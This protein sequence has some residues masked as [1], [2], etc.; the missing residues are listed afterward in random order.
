MKNMKTILGFLLVLILMATIAVAESGEKY[1][2]DGEKTVIVDMDDFCLYL[3]GDYTANDNC[4]GISGNF[5]FNLNCVIENKSDKVF[6]SV[7]YDGVI[8]GWS[9]GSVFG[10]NGASNIQ[11]G[12]KTKSSI[13]FT[14]DDTEIVSFEELESMSL[15]FYVKDEA[16]TDM[17]KAETGMIHFHADAQVVE[18]AAPEVISVEADQTVSTSTQVVNETVIIYGDYETL[19]VG[20]KG[21][22]VKQLQRTLIEKGFLSGGA[23]GIY[24]KGT[25]GGVSK[26]QESIGAEATGTAD[27]ETQKQLFGGLDVLAALKEETWFFN[28]GDDTILNVMSFTDSTATITQFVYDGNGRHE[29]GKNEYPYV[30]GNENI[31][32]TLIDGSELVIPFAASGSK[33]VLGNNEYWSASAVDAGLQGYWRCRYSDD[34]LA[35]LGISQFFGNE[36]YVYLGEGT[37]KHEHA[38]EGINLRKGEYYY[39]INQGSYKLGMGCF[40]TDMMHGHE[41]WF[42][43]IDGK[44]VLFRYSRPFEPTTKKFPGQNG[45]KF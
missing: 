9:L 43:I 34:S 6:G 21:D 41:F 35:I 3:K 4:N 42:N 14:T 22:A 44:P 8:N 40:E 17:F 20:S 19:E 27:A 23:D 39:S 36:E 28:G 26:F 1:A 2:V 13:W 38:N 16:Y 5:M 45:Y 31:M 10:M 18:A 32:I 30:L 33:L 7:Q 11:P 12:T 25:A 29:N 37:I 24:G 15:T